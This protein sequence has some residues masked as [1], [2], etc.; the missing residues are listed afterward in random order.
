VAFWVYL[1]ERDQLRRPDHTWE[2]N[3]RMDHKDLSLERVDYLVQD[4][5]R[6]QGFV[7]TAMN[8]R[9]SYNAGNFLTS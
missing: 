2:A 7:N 9:V 3:S 8:L 5:D 1:R 6:W 4:R